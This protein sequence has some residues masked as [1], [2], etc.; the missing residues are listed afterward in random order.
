MVVGGTGSGPVQ[1]LVAHHG[2]YHE[3]VPGHHLQLATAVFQKRRLND[4][5]RLLAGTSGHAE[6][7]ALYAE[8]LVPEMGYLREAGDLLRMLDSQLF[9]TARVV[10]GDS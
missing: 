9:R 4:F 1:H 10:L 6:G 3:G 7:W 5:Q 8:R 2:V